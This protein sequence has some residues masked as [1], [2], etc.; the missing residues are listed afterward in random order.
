M[1]LNFEVKSE[2]NEISS[3][4]DQLISR[5][6]N[7]VKTPWHSMRTCPLFSQN[8]TEM[9]VK[10]IAVFFLL[11]EKPYA[12]ERFALQKELA[13]PCIISCKKNFIV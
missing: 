3:C 10:T 1:T 5:I 11:H 7:E 2:T 13:L 8:H 9:F 12:T 6:N 4:S